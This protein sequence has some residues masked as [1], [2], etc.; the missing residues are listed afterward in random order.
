MN[1]CQYDIAIYPRI[2]ELLK[3]TPQL[4]LQYWLPLPISQLHMSTDC[5]L[6]EASLSAP[7]TELIIAAATGADLLPPDLSRESLVGN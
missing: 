5:Y 6:A 3:Q 1:T 2:L 7:L 4:T